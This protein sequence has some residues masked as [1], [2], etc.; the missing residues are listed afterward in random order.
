[1]E[2]LAR[3]S[4]KCDGYSLIEVLTA[5]LLLTIVMLACMESVVLYAQTNMRNV[6]RDE[7]VRVTQDTLYNLRS[8]GFNNV[9]SSAD[10]GVTTTTQLVKNLRSTRWRF[11]VTITVIDVDPQM[12]SARAVTT[13]CFNPTSGTV[14]PFLHTPFTHQASI[15]IPNLP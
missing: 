3:S 9:S 11:D 10:P 12:K 13:C 5:L 2:Q 15:L 1:M 7:A 14:A 8:R 4:K 6:L